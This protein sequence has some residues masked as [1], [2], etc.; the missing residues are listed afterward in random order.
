MTPQSPDAGSPGVPQGAGEVLRRRTDERWAEIVDDVVARALRVTRRSSPIQVAGLAGAVTV[1]EQVV[2]TLLH[3]ALA[4]V[5]GGRPS[6]IDVHTD[7][8][9][10]YTGVLVVVAVDYGSSVLDVADEVRL[11]AGALLRELL[12]PVEPPVTVSA[13]HVHVDDVVPP[14]DGTPPTS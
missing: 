14:S 11:R 1:S 10:H 13:M 9:G 3:E 7:E 8:G 2:V 5:P 4:T 12:G 6:A